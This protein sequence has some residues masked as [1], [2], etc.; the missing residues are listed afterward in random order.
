MP[1]RQAAVIGAGSWGTA[2]AKLLSD[3]GYRISL[4]G[5]RQDHVDEIVENRENL[6]YL[7]GFKLAENESYK[8]N[9]QNHC[10][11]S[12]RQPEM[13]SDPHRRID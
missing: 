11:Q 4:W 9:L 8:F 12:S 7:P 3:K 10:D 6:T 5:H 1:V 13:A 2:L